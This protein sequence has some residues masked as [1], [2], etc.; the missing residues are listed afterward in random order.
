MLLLL[1]LSK[2]VRKMFPSTREPSAAANI[3]G[4]NIE[5][6]L[7]N[8]L[9]A[10]VDRG[11]I[12]M[13]CQPDAIAIGKDG[14]FFIE[15]KGQDRFLAPPFDGHGMPVRQVENYMKLYKTTGMPTQFLVWEDNVSF[16]QWL[17]VLESGES[18]DTA[19]TVKT[20]RRIYPLSAFNVW[21]PEDGEVNAAN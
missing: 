14:P 9:V 8:N 10:G 17:H 3:R 2:V 4:R 15:A 19:G 11:S 12:E 13:F 18:F 21:K 16:W 6:K 1:V 20:P 7:F 5:N